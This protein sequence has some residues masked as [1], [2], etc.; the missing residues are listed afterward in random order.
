MPSHWLLN[1]KARFGPCTHLI[2]HRSVPFHIIEHG[3]LALLTTMELP[4]M[5]SCLGDFIISIKE[6][7]FL[8]ENKPVTIWSV[9]SNHNFTRMQIAKPHT[10]WLSR[11]L[12]FPWSWV[13]SPV[14]KR[15]RP[16]QWYVVNPDGWRVA[17]NQQAIIP[18]TT[19]HHH[20]TSPIL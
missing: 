8:N 10:R 9:S 13:W 11:A 5:V 17:S 1:P 3:W 7:W 20:A 19:T 4:K 18:F 12:K 2:P 15:E 16:C 6:I 14:K